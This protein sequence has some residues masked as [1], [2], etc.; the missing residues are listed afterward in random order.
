[1]YYSNFTAPLVSSA[2][3]AII[4]VVASES[5][6]LSGSAQ[7]TITANP[8]PPLTVLASPRPLSITPGG[9]VVIAIRVTN[10][11]QPVLGAII[12]PPKSSAGGT[13]S[14]V[15]DNGNGNYTIVFTAPLQS[16][17]P[18]VTIVASKPGFSSGQ[19]TVTV[20]VN[21]IPNLTNLK[22]VGFPFIYLIAGAAL[23]FLVV[24]IALASRR[25]NVPSSPYHHPA[26]VEPPTYASRPDFGEGLSSRL[27]GAL[28][29]GLAAI[30]GS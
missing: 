22:V 24:L 5:G 12:P 27:R 30:G 26:E 6:F 8:F 9:E 20:T 11:T 23:L 28:F 1:L 13:F 14:G 19:D 18:A 21:G 15:T 3:V 4:Q 7:T 17:N 10:G 25:K 2:T 29:T 16:S